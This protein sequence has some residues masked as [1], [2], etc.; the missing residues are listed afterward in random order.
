MLLLRPSSASID[1]I[2]EDRALLVVVGDGDEEADDEGDNAGVCLPASTMD[3]AEAC[4]P[5]EVS[6]WWS[7]VVADDHIQFGGRRV[8]PL[9]TPC[10]EDLDH[11]CEGNSKEI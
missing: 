11:S 1:E 8:D 10:P 5:P 4:N 7:V 2:L 6:A 9:W 3:A